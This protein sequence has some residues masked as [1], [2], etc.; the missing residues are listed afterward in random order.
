MKI[1]F[2]GTAPGV[3]VKNRRF[4]S[5]L[6]EAG[7]SLYLIDAGSG[8]VNTMTDMGLDVTAIRSVF[9][10]HAHLDHM[11]GIIDLADLINWSATFSSASV[12]YYIP[13]AVAI[14]LV[15][16]YLT[17]LSAPMS[18][19]ANR[20]H[21][22]GADFVY[23]DGNIRVTPYPNGHLAKDNRPSYSFLIECEG[24][25]VLVTGDLSANLEL[26]DFPSVARL[27]RCDVII[28][29]LAHF[30][31]PTALSEL[32]S[33]EVGAV[34]FTHVKQPWIR[35]GE[36]READASGKYSFPMYSAHDGLEIIL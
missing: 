10:T 8:V 29:E 5:V 2:L 35:V 7:E 23:D 21:A 32:T 34:Y 33:C 17:T 24:K 36:I 3:P 11:N 4:S 25:R 18:E 13:E 28:S 27:K 14:D 9:I 20:F 22:Y 6:I 19:R 12:D 16:N 30:D 1:T 15:K 26:S 31:L